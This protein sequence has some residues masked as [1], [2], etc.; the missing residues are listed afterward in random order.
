MNDEDLDLNFLNNLNIKAKNFIAFYKK[1]KRKVNSSYKNLHFIKFVVF[2]SY[3]IENYHKCLSFLF[4]GKTSI[5]E[6]KSE[7]KIKNR[8]ENNMNFLKIDV[9]IWK[10]KSCI[11][12]D[13]SKNEFENDYYNKYGI[14]TIIIQL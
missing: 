7:N 12:N 2:K 14:F 5:K 13:E 9:T 4:F 10:N 11:K 8:V 1:K 6:L 3:N